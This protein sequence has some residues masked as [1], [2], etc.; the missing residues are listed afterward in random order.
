MF[1]EVTQLVLGS[2]VVEVLAIDV[3]N[4]L[5]EVEALFFSHDVSD[6]LGPGETVFGN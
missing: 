2:V 4:E 1:E 6:Q 3:E 5:V